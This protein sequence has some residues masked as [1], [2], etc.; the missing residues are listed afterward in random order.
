M[1]A[2]PS[3]STPAT[4]TPLPRRAGT[5][6][7]VA[8]SF[9]AAWNG[10]VETALHQRNMRI[11]VVA[12]VLVGILGSSIAFG[13][14]ERL[15]LLLSVFLVLSAEVANTALEALVDLVTRER[16][17]LARAAKDAGAGAVLV[18][19]A[20][21]VVVLAV[22]VANARAALEAPGVVL[23]PPVMAGLPLAVTTGVLLLP[24]Q[25]R[26]AVD[27]ALVAAGIVLLG[28]VARWTE[29][30]VFTAL[31]AVL[32]VVAVAVALRRRA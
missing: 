26:R 31:A 29:D 22:V 9:R 20:A 6:R 7:G 17:E 1:Q 13:V 15:A 3:R 5:W 30:A 21:S 27:V 18:L 12:G 16:R 23:R 14:V 8:A 10:V 32:F 28:V 11:H 2:Q 25:R 24:F 19:A 4:V